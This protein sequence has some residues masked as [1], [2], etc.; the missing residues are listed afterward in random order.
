MGR[1][2]PLHKN[3]NKKMENKFSFKKGWSQVQQ[4]EV[5]TVREKLMEALNLKT[6][7]AFLNRVNGLVEP[8]I[9]EHEA[10]ERIFKEHGIKD[11]WGAN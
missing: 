9:S 4:R 6:R 10:I 5:A 7:M 1:R 3:N 2:K 11:V 8:K